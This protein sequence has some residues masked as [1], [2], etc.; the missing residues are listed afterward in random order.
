MFL[1]LYNT[2]KDINVAEI[3]NLSELNQAY[4]NKINSSNQL[5]YNKTKVDLTQKEDTFEKNL[6]QKLLI[7]FKKLL[8]KQKKLL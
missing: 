7:Q 2:P 1:L 6:L 3:N 8:M 4:I 5:N